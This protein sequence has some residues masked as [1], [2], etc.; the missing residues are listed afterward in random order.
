MYVYDKSSAD[1]KLEFWRCQFRGTCKVRLHQDESTGDVVYVSAAHSD[2][3]EASSTEI[4]ELRNSLK[5]RAESTQEAPA[6]LINKRASRNPII[7][8]N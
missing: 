6:Q 3:P 8:S 7:C 4:A 2:P 1:K 5:V